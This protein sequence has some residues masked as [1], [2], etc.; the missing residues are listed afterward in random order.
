[1][2][3]KNRGSCYYIRMRKF[4]GKIIAITGGSSGIGKH[5]CETFSADNVVVDLSRSAETSD[6]FLSEGT[7]VN[8]LYHIK[9]DV[10]VE[11]DVIAAFDKIK[12]AFGKVDVLI[13]NAGYGVSGAVELLSDEEVERIFKVNFMGVFRCCKYALPLM[14]KGGKI[15]N[16]SSAC[17]IFA[18]PFRGM[19]C[20]SKAAVSMLSYSLREE[21]KPYGIDVTAICP[22]D[23][24]TPFTRNRVKN[25]TTNE[26]YG[27]RIKDADDHISARE[28]KRMSVDYACRKIEKIIVKKKYKPFYIV[29]GKYKFLYALYRIFPLG[30]I[31][32]ATGKMFAPK[33]N[34]KD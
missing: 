7:G 32:G 14:D 28:N 12:A 20:A 17:A 29:G 31:L 13:N 1:M 26:R 15:V 25:F 30:A 22:G 19:Y 27:S 11:A 9:C 23:V 2:V 8:G 33:Q 21:V 5:I 16:V 6:V 4:K 34:D 24:K 10:S 3:D 18:L